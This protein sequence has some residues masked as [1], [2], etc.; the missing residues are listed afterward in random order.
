MTDYQIA[1]DVSF[2]LLDMKK[3]SEILKNI[4]ERLKKLEEKP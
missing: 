1:K 4:E 2:L 3:I